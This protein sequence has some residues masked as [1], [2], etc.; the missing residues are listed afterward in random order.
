MCRAPN[1]HFSD[2]GAEKLRE[3]VFPTLKRELVDA[4]VEWHAEHPEGEMTQDVARMWWLLGVDVSAERFLGRVRM[5][6]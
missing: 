5:V 6:R 2:E 1:P 3:L 4:L